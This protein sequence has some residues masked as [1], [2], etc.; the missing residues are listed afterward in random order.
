MPREGFT[1]DANFPVI[2]AEK[3]ILH[4]TLAIPIEEAPMSSL[5]AGERA[6]MVCDYASA[7]IPKKVAELLVDYENPVSGTT[8]SYDNT[9]NTLKAYGKS[10]HGSTPDQGAN[11]LQAMLAFLGTC[12][13]Q[14]LAAY[15]I[16]FNDILGLKE[17][18]DETGVLTMS[19][20][21]ATFENGVLKITTDI[22]FP[23]TYAKES[24]L[25]KLDE[26]GLNYEINNYQA[27]LYNDKQGSLIQTLTR[28]FNEATGANEQPIAIGGGTYARALECGCGFGPEVNGEEQTIH[29][30]N[31]YITF[32]RIQLISNIYY[33]ALKA[34]ASPKYTRIATITV[35]KQKTQK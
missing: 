29:Q 28:V 22:R 24:I 2:Y 5:K 18:Q 33:K 25:E 20:D 11:A 14:C 34:I 12:N 7:F 16:L 3:G 27:P 19:P 6:N 35:K 10:A 13:E 31:E 4:F 1:P 32:E 15:D 30:A 17:L 21:V 8:L 26:T 23:A 9:T